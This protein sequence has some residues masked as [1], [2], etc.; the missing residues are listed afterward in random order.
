MIYGDPKR[1]SVVAVIVISKEASLIWAKQNLPEIKD[2]EELCES[3]AF[4][5]M[6]KSQISLKAS[7]KQM[8]SYE[9]P[10]NLFLTTKNF[11]VENGMLTGT[12]KLC[13][14]KII[15]AYKDTIEQLYGGGK[16]NQN[17][18]SE[19]ERH[20]LYL[21]KISN[22]KSLAQQ[23]RFIF[24]YLTKMEESQ[25]DDSSGLLDHGLD[26]LL[27]VT[28]VKECEKQLSVD[29]PV[30]LLMKNAS[31]Q[32]LE[33]HILEGKNLF[34]LYSERQKI[35]WKQVAQKIWDEQCSFLLQKKEEILKGNAPKDLL[36]A[37]KNI[38]LTG[39]TGFFGS[40]LL[41]SLLKHTRELK[42]NFYC[43]VRGKSEEDC[44][45][46]IKASLSF[47]WEDHVKASDDKRV[48]ALMGDCSE[49]LFG[50]EEK[51]WN[52]LC[53][54]IDVVYHVAARVH[55]LLSFDQL[56]NANVDGT[57]EALKFSITSK[58]KHLHYISTSSVLADE[59]SEEFDLIELENSKLSS[60]NGYTISKWV[61][62][63][64]VDKAKRECNL[65]CTIWRP[66]MIAS[67][68]VYGHGNV[69]DWVT[70]FIC[71]AI[72]VNLFPK[73]D[74]DLHS[75]DWSGVDYLS[76]IISQI[77][78]NVNANTFE[79][80]KAFHLVHPSTKTN[81]QSIFPHLISFGYNQI[82]LVDYEIFGKK[83]EN[84]EEKNPLFPLKSSFSVAFPQSQ[85]GKIDCSNVLK[86][87]PNLK[88][89]PLGEKFVHLFLK[90]LITQK[91]IDPPK[92]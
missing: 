22:S 29:I 31:F 7:E 55:S 63:V 71:G 73:L 18:L 74:G 6:L 92:N 85:P 47:C 50:L 49:H 30:E 72:Q 40:H 46:R 59:T 54:T 56:K 80:F 32:D 12:F 68:S 60:L 43:L 33:K 79:K 11:S 53:E 83:I 86:L 61:A 10:S 84:I 15:E 82:K 24:C 76:E 57:I 16:C 1:D 4:K 87:C 34:T 14:G 39:V 75:I 52:E 37:P 36:L 45:K 9:I 5:K 17:V 8:K 78:L 48:F 26:S 88:C 23:L 77:T 91:M 3:S 67:D 42:S 27:S 44:M 38:F 41:S 90:F 62:D 64:L 66:G 81:I 51:R 58:I 19:E 35:K 89:P 69:I 28:Y 70:R 20:N 25:V 13:R 21:Q 2:V 65:I